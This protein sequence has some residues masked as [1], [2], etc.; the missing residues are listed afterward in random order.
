MIKP[1]Q[2]RFD[3]RPAQANLSCTISTL[4]L[5]VTLL[6][7]IA[8]DK[9]DF[10]TDPIYPKQQEQTATGSSGPVQNRSTN[11]SLI[12]D[13]FAHEES[14]T[15]MI[16]VNGYLWRASLDTLSFMPLSSADPFGGV[17]I[18]DW[19]SPPETPSERF[20]VTAYILGRAL[21][22]DGIRV[23]VFRQTRN[24][25]GNWDNMPVNDTVASDLENTILTRARE[26]KVRTSP[27]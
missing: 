3:Y 9:L 25:S 12:G 24:E 20:K 1:R 15:L 10:G 21:Q 26:F 17:I 11:S 6:V 19:Y 18:T 22:S 14:N 16:A 4:L 7:L 27:G 13:L 5:A 23:S 2:C 8:C